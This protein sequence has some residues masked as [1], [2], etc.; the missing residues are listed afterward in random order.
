[1]ILLA[2]VW[3]GGV[4]ALAGNESEPSVELL[5]ML[6]VDPMDPLLPEEGAEPVIFS[7]NGFRPF[8]TRLANQEQKCG[9]SE[10]S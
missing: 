5:S 10:A 8:Q 3:L 9:L 1:M 4:G 6:P 7:S 2:G